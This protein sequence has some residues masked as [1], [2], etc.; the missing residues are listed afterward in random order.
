MVE[1]LKVFFWK[2]SNFE[3]IQQTTNK[4][5]FPRYKKL[6]LHKSSVTGYYLTNVNV[7][8]GNSLFY[9]GNL[10]VVIKRFHDIQ[11]TYSGPPNCTTADQLIALVYGSAL[12]DG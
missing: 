6:L 9:H 11:Y 4:H 12:E 3:E 8:T 1:F 7:L 2:L 10:C 5:N